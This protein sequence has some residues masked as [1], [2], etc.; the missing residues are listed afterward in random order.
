MKRYRCV[1]SFNRNAKPTSIMK[2]RVPPDDKY[3]SFVH[4]ATQLLPKTREMMRDAAIGP[5]PDPDTDH[6]F[7]SEYVLLDC[8]KCKFKF[9]C[10]AEPEAEIIFEPPAKGS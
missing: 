4:G 2:E 3:Q 8:N 9:I 6:N 7:W 1:G 10:V 5:V